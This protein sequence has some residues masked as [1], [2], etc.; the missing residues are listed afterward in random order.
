[1]RDPQALPMVPLGRTAAAAG[2][3]V[4][5][6]GHAAAVGG[7]PE[8]AGTVEPAR[9]ADAAV[10]QMLEDM[11]PDPNRPIPPARYTT[12]LVDKLGLGDSIFDKS[13]AKPLLNGAAV[14]ERVLPRAE[15][16]DFRRIMQA[17][18]EWLV[19]HGYCATEECSSEVERALSKHLADTFPEYAG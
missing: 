3:A 15:G 18:E 12:F 9:A 7:A 10:E 19:R 14:K 1:M 16:G 2:G 8:Q 5:Q 17:Q 13:Y 4:V 6:L 11:A